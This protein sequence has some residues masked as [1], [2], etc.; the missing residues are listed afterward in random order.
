MT[1]YLV[2]ER[3]EPVALVG[4]IDLACEIVCS[5]PPGYYALDEIQLDPLD[6]GPGARA[7]RGSPCHPD[8]GTGDGQRVRSRPTISPAKS[9]TKPIPDAPGPVRS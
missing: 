6:S 4:S 9:P 5:E 2:R 1:C 3:G 8:G 7:G